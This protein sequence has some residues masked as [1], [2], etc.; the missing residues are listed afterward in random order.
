MFSYCCCWHPT[1][2]LCYGGSAVCCGRINVSV[3]GASSVAESRR[4]VYRSVRERELVE[5]LGPEGTEAPQEALNAKAVDVI[6]RVQD[7][8]T[9]LDFARGGSEPC[10]VSEQVDLLIAQATSNERL[11]QCYVGWCPFW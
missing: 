7:K 9:G 11:C 5:A 3:P 6:R 8:L 2:S 4:S 1:F 10:D